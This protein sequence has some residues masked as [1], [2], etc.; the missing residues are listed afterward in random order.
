M[1]KPRRLAVVL[2]ALFR[3]S[4]FEDGLSEELRFHI[5][6]Y[7]ADLVRSGMSPQDAARQAR[8]EFGSLEM[9]KDDCRRA[10]GLRMLD[11]IAQDLRY[12]ARMMRR[13]PGFTA[14]ALATIALCLGA[15]L[16]IFAVVDAVLLRPLPFPDADRLVRIHNTY[17]QAGVP[18]DGASVANYYERRAAVSALG[19]VSLYREGSAL[20]GEPGSIERE[21]IM[22]VTAD[23]FATLGVGPALG[24]AFVEEETAYQASRVAILTD[25][26]WRQRFNAD[27]AAVGRTLRVDGADR[28]IVGILPADFRF[29]SSKA[30]LFVPLASEPADRTP[31]RRHWGSSSQMVAR[32]APA[33]TIEAAQ[34]AVDAHNAAAEIGT[35]TAKMMKEAG[36]RSLVTP[37]RAEHVA[38]V[39][40][41]LLI[42]QA[43]AIGLLLIGGVNLVN[44]LLIR[45]TARS[46]EL[47]VRQAIGGSRARIARQVLVETTL[48][49]LTGAV[50]GLALGAAGIRLLDVLGTGTLPLGSTI[51]FNTS[52]ALAG[53][54]AAIAL[55]VLLALPVAWI[56]LRSPAVTSLAGETRSATAGAGVQRLRHAFLVGQVALAFA[57]LS[58]AGLLALSLRE[59]VAISPGFHSS[60]VLS[61][62]ITIPVSS[63]PDTAA[64]QVLVD[65]LMR[66]L[67]SQPGIVTAGVVTNVPFSGRDIKSAITVKGW[68][69]RA[70]ESVRGH[71]GYGVGGRYFAALGLRLVEGRVLEPAEIQRG[72]RTVVVDEDFARRYWP[73]GG[74]LGR[75]IF[76]GPREGSDADAYTIVGIVGAA[77][78]AGLTDAAATGAVFFPYG[79]RFDTELFVVARTALAPEALAASLR[80]VV[81]ATDPTLAV[82]DVRSMDSRIADS[83]VARR[84]PTVLAA[85]FAGLA[86]LLTAIGTYGVISYAVAQ[87]R[88]EIALRMALGAHPTQVGRAF[89]WQGLRLV[90]IGSMLGLAC[91]WIAGRAMQGLLF[92][93]PPV[94]VPTLAGAAA[95]VAVVTIAACLIP[96]RRAAR[97]SPMEA[98]TES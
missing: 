15:N 25:G 62:Q 58:G 22:R 79:A 86:L 59:V 50:G 92:G 80:R 72:D 1:L 85:L 42:V 77:R 36:F 54:A 37:L 34:D 70:G 47:A 19:S 21:P 84:S 93:V 66:G 60:Q 16:A 43:G 98:L 51:A 10:R 52:L 49:T 61:G 31:A 17:P 81:R 78:Q 26:F 88:R 65:R 5:E 39:R 55:A 13:A 32:L 68:V 83:L 71:Y 64:R 8:V 28:L 90:T 69:P 67:E 44:L 4:R 48:L 41:M 97:I 74:G 35:P 23:F 18:D 87:R 2:R 3:R 20:V 7:T 82:S 29:L 6:E 76:A 91:A 95:I 73:D 38:A 75:K 56:T 30:R 53:I 12:A 94:H 33:V 40:P 27:P 14:T 89:V 24:R 57:L 96:S 11:E 45:A 46:R 9:V 63:Y